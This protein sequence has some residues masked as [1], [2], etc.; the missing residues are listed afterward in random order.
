MKNIYIVVLYNS[1]IMADYASNFNKRFNK[2]SAKKDEMRLD[3]FTK[4]HEWQA[5]IARK[6]R[7]KEKSKNRNSM[8]DIGL[9]EKN[10]QYID[11]FRDV[12]FNSRKYC[13]RYSRDYRY[14]QDFLREREQVNLMRRIR[15]ESWPSDSIPLS[16]PDKK[17]DSGKTWKIPNEIPVHNAKYYQEYPS[18]GESDEPEYVFPIL[19][20]YAVF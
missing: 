6:K 15:G 4:K 16:I 14:Y 19:E 9:Y 11:M 17:N 2:S 5:G 3:K 13:T 18:I 1:Q 8:R 10:E 20:G 12:N 7:D